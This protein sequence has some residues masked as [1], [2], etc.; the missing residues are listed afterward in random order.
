MVNVPTSTITCTYALSPIQHRQEAVLR[1]H[2][3]RIDR[4]EPRLERYNHRSRPARHRQSRSRSPT[5]R[6]SS[7]RRRSRSPEPRR[8]FHSSA[9]GPGRQNKLPA[10]PICLGRHR[11]HVGECR[12]PQMWNGKRATCTR[13]ETGKILNKYRVVLCADWQRPG[14]CRE[15]DQGHVHECSGCGSTEHGADSCK[16]AQT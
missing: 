1:W 7:H 6:T 11:H 4:G 2:E 9:P 5:R 14:R 15:M 16:H 8:S 3:D 12:A 10:C 13:S